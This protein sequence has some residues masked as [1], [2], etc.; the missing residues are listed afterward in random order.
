MSRPKN[1]PHIPADAFTDTIRTIRLS[2]AVVGE[3]PITVCRYIGRKM[4]SATI[5]PQPKELS[6]SVQRAT[7]SPRMASGISGSRAVISRSTKP[8]P[9]TTA[10]AASATM[11]GESQA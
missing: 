6:M 5:G 4:F 8:A 11:T 9:I 1:W 7:G 2:P 3:R 10:A